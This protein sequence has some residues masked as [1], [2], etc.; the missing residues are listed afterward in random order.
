MSDRAVVAET[1]PETYVDRK[2]WA[3]AL[4]PIWLCLPLMGI[5]LAQAT[6]SG[7]GTG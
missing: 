2:R 7:R 3:W 5:G 6:A 4:S 1:E